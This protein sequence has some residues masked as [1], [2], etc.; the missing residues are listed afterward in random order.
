M[1]RKKKGGAVV[2]RIRAALQ[3][4]PINISVIYEEA[5]VRGLPDSLRAQCWLALLNISKDDVIEIKFF[6]F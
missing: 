5:N 6:S 2:R 3:E 4:E 1:V